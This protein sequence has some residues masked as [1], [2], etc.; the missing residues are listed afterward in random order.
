MREIK[1]RGKTIDRF[2]K[3]HVSKWVYGCLIETKPNKVDGEWSAYIMERPTFIPSKTIPVE[4]FIEVDFK[5][6]G[7]FVGLTDK[8]GKEIYE[9]DIIKNN[10]HN[11]NGKSIGCVWVVKFGEHQ[12]SEDFY[13]CSAYGW[14]G[15]AKNGETHTLH[16]LPSDG[17]YD[18]EIIGTVHEHPE[19]IKYK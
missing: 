4:K 13:A 15:E 18:V 9:G 8:H 12:T 3:N 7:Q 11:I 10:W 2:N 16:D 5:T 6:V 1:F 19:L 17:E 14:Y